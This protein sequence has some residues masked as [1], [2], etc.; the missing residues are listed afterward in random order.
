M[1]RRGL[2]LG[3]GAVVVV[4]GA[5]LAATGVLSDP[6]D[7]PPI[8]V[9]ASGSEGARAAGEIAAPTPSTDNPFDLP[10]PV[11]E[12][13]TEAAR[14]LVGESIEPLPDPFSLP[15]IPVLES[16]TDAAWIAH[17]EAIADL[18]ERERLAAL[19][20]DA[21]AT[22]RADSRFPR[23]PDEDQG[24]YRF[25]LRFRQRI[26]SSEGLGTITYFVNSADNSQ[27]FPAWGLGNWLPEARF[28]QGELEFVIRQPDGDWLACGRHD[29][30]G[31][32]CL[33]LGDNLG[34]AFAWLRDTGWHRDLLASVAGTPQ[35]LG[36]APRAGLQGLRGRGQD[37]YLQLWVSRAPSPVATRMPFL[38]LGVG[39]MKDDRIRANRSVHR[40]VVE[41]GDRDGGD[42][43]F[44]LVELAAGRLERDTRGYR[45]VTAFSG[46]G[47]DE[48]TAIGR[49][50]LDLQA[51]AMAIQ[52]DL[53]ACPAGRPGRDCRETHRARMKALEARFREQALDYG[54]RH[55][56]PVGD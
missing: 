14:V 3:V 36:E 46:E 11:L 10:I 52:R 43:V 49:H 44:D 8:E 38:G 33:R 31:P 6:V 47:L 50:G 12:S 23:N 41:G 22:Y 53:D 30:L 26:D 1:S 29:E 35:T 25:D 19:R 40:L 4:A 5:A 39:V 42:L 21:E 20:R 56:L 18:R 32:A 16:G 9:V 55:G 13:G 54:R 24:L 37:A 45:M 27:L 7:P 34:A 2:A 48:A 15:P 51:E 17:G 28:P